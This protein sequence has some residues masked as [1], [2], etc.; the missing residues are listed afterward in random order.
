MTDNGKKTDSPMKWMPVVAGALRRSDGKYLMHKRPPGKHHAGLWE[1]PGGKVELFETPAQALARELNEELGVV[2][3]S[4]DC[5][6][7]GFAESCAKSG[8]LPIVI[9]LYT[10][11]HWADE[12]RPMEGGE[13]GWFTPDEIGHLAKPPLDVDLTVRL[14]EKGA[15]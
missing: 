2:V 12:P 10:L 15:I 1:F 11:T 8:Q 14:F 7:A 5:Q 4:L 6:P 3:D 13:L 9:L